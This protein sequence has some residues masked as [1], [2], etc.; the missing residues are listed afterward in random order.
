MCDVKLAFVNFE[1]VVEEFNKEKNNVKSLL[2]LLL[3]RGTQYIVDDFT[4]NVDLPHDVIEALIKNKIYDNNVY[5]VFI[6]KVQNGKQTLLEYSINNEELLNIAI[7]ILGKDQVNDYVSQNNKR[8]LLNGK[9]KSMLSNEVSYS[10]YLNG[11]VN[12]KR[13]RYSSDTVFNMRDLG[14]TGYPCDFFNFLVENE[15]LD[16]VLIYKILIRDGLRLMND[17]TN[18]SENKYSDSYLHKKIDSYIDKAKLSFNEKEFNEILLESLKICVQIKDDKEFE[19]LIKLFGRELIEKL[20]SL[21]I[22]R[23]DLTPKMKILLGN[24]TEYTREERC[25][26]CEA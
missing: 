10:R 17:Y 14:Y 5:K 25:I 11:E 15:D 16:S 18:S 24:D 20:C 12:M 6:D 7:N 4:E 8:N 9:M 21:N 2:H 3:S 1:G 19:I 22:K 26:S 23:G 13:T